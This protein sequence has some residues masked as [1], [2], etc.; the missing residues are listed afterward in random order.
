MGE[1]SF[2]KNP[3]FC[4]FDK[5]FD[6]PTSSCLFDYWSIQHF[7]WQGVAYIIFHALLGINQFGGAISLLLL[8]T[9]LH[10]VE[11]YLDNV[12][13]FSL[14]GIIIDK[15]GPLIDK[16]IDPANRGPDNDYLDNSVG[17]VLSGSLACIVIIIY[18]LIFNRLPVA[19]YILLLIPVMYLML[20][21]RNKFYN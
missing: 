5:K 2:K 15:I 3:Q 12:G 14:Q 20:R 1:R 13:K 7:Y 16:K 10:A 17:D 8:L 19:V 21:K 9:F 4:L 6:K 11:E 18:W